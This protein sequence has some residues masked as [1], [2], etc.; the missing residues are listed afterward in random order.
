VGFFVSAASS[1]AALYVVGAEEFGGRGGRGDECWSA[2]VLPGWNFEIRDLQV[3]AELSAIGF[4]V[5]L[6][7]FFGCSNDSALLTELSG[8]SL[9]VKEAVL[10]FRSQ[11][12]T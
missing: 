10:R 11:L 1:L 9:Q 5:V 7:V 8:W 6:S 12:C 3:M 4:L 2:W